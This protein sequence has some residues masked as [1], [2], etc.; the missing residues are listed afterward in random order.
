MIITY[1]T[2]VLHLPATPLGMLPGCWKVEHRCSG[3]HQRVEPNLLIPHAR[4]HEKE[5]VAAI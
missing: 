2:C 1:R 3:C 5:V 4:E